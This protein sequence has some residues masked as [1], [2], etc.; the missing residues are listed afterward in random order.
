MD[1]SLGIARVADGAS[2]VPA[3][4]IL[5]RRLQRQ[6]PSLLKLALALDATVRPAITVDAELARQ[7]H[8]ERSRAVLKLLAEGAKI[9]QVAHEL[10]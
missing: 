1:A 5:S 6:R 8:S 9:C 2:T 4:T 3:M 10:G 7:V